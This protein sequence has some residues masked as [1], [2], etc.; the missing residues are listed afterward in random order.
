[1]SEVTNEGQAS[2]QL[3]P[4]PMTSTASLVLDVA[5]MESIM[6]MADVMAG[7]RT[8]IP[9][10]LKGSSSDCAAVIMQAMQ[11]KMNPFAVAQKTHIV[12]GTLGYEG[13]LVNAA[14]TA[15]GV[16]K[17]R[18]NY[19][20]FGAWERII[21][22][23]KVVNV[24]EKGTRGKD[25]YKKAYQFHASDYDLNLETGLGIRIWA[26]LRGET[27]PRELTLLLAQA[28]VRN[29]PLWATDPRQQLAY[30]AVKRW[31]RLY[32]PDVIL[33][34]YTPDELEEG[35]REIRDITPVGA[36]TTQSIAAAPEASADLVA[37]AKS[38]ASKGVAAYQQFWKD[39]GAQGRKS[40]AAHHEGWKA[41]AT[42][43]D[44]S[45]TIDAEPVLND[46]K[47]LSADMQTMLDDLKNDA[48]GGVEML[49]AMW[50]R[51]SD[52]TKDALS[53][54]YPKLMAIAEATGG[55]K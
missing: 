31:A 50:E 47:T 55:V 51:L 43:A 39:A 13:Q 40:L 24:P 41:D 23:T 36:D 34:V 49:G 18:F 29:S 42:A 16:T 2:M 30:L 4:M 21:G 46:K 32:A 14:I 48:A 19:E 9:A 15:S 44:Q 1:M 3:A 10:H 25:D 45:R 54:E 6:R 8:T 26:T 5:S 20:W 37:Q 7:S 28:T 52:A 27:E 11:W 12:N 22:K 33:G 38:A 35:N 53:D 17:D